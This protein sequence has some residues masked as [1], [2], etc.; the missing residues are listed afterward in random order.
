[1]PRLDHVTITAADFAVSLAF[2]DAVFAALGW[3]RAV[4]LVDEE[5]SDSPVE[6]VGW[7]DPASVW[8][9]G[10][11][12]PTSGLHLALDAADAATVERFHAAAVAA[13]GRSH[14]APRRWPIIARG[15][16]NAI[17]YD[18]GGNLVEVLAPE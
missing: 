6:A 1:M 10:G 8:L 15:L 4:D 3:V 7:G 18:P 14:D 17:V 12:H 16:F 9:V 2:Y 5:E 11:E 13:G